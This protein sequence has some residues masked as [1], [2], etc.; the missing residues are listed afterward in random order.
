MKSSTPSFSGRS[1]SIGD[2]STAPSAGSSPASEL[3]SVLR[4][5]PNAVFTT[6]LNRRSSHPSDVRELRV[7]RITPLFTFGAG[8]NTVS[9]TV[10][11]YSQS[12][13]A[14]SSTDSMP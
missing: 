14:C 6:V 11:R 1:F 7:S 5:I 2:S 3:R 13:H 10:K 8:V 4:R 12:Y 9:S